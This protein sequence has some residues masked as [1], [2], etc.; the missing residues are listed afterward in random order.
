MYAVIRAGGKQLK[1][2][3]GDVIEVER[4]EATPGGG[5]TFSEV[6][7]LADGNDVKLGT[8]LV[9]KA[10]VFGTVLDMIRSPKILVFKKKRRKQYRRTRGHR[11]YLMRVRIDELG[12]AQER[13]RKPEPAGAAAAEPQVQPAEKAGK[14]EVRKEVRKEVKKEKKAAAKPAPVA[15]KAARPAKATAKKPAK[16]ETAA[17]SKSAKKPEPKGK[18][19]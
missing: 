15:R 8:P 12:F 13:T 14:K 7:M 11:Q 4:R 16:K 18:K 5:V 3:E 2:S 10:N 9:D 1:V 17:K 19:R 6:L